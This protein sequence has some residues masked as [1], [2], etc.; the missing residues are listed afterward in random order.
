MSEKKPTTKQKIVI[1][2]LITLA[3]IL[4]ARFAAL[5][6]ST[7][8]GVVTFYFA[9]AF[10]IV[11]ALWFGVWGV[12]AAYIGCLIGSGVPA[13]LPL[14]VNLYWSLADV[15]QVLIP[16][17][18]FKLLKIDVALK[19][20]KDASVFLLFAWLL[21]NLAGAVWGTTMFILNGK[22]SSEFSSVFLNWFIGNLIVTVL[23]T[24]LILK[25]ATPVLRKKRILIGSY[26]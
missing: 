4:L 1:F 17:V 20:R 15:W 25:L 9:V 26:W 14:Q 23:I 11:F 22:F 7:I 5:T 24:P 13:G 19:T 16:I 3:N 6:T 12:V 8:P 10:M 2:T 21:N 18:S